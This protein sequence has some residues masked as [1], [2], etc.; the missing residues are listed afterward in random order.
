MIILSYSELITYGCFVI[1]GLFALV[2][3]EGYRANKMAD[4]NIKLTK[5]IESK[6]EYIAKDKEDKVNG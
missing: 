1:T 5:E 2:L 3:L 4:E 6:M